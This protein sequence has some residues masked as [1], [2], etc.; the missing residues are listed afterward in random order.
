MQQ[1]SSSPTP[2]RR[3]PP[4]KPQQTPASQNGQS[5]EQR[6]RP[7]NEEQGEARNQARPQR[8]RTNTNAKPRAAQG[9]SNN[10]PRT[11]SD[12]SRTSPAPQQQTAARGKVAPTGRRQRG[13]T[14]RTDGL[15]VAPQIPNLRDWCFEFRGYV[16]WMAFNQLY[17]PLS[18]GRNHRAYLV[19]VHAGDDEVNPQYLPE[20]EELRHM[21]VLAASVK[22]ARRLLEETVCSRVEAISLIPVEEY[23]ARLPIVAEPEAEPV[24]NEPPSG[25]IL[26]LEPPPGLDEPSE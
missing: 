21:F 20:V 9:S 10:Q 6:R 19:D 16:F 23:L 12:A 13:R 1:G 22:E 17:P 26:P 14:K 5:Q 7:S 2:R 15:E 11:R 18:D 8:S 4:R 25:L 3:R 24:P